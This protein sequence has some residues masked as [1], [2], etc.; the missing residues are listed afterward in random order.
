MF[1]VVAVY[2]LCVSFVVFLFEGFVLVRCLFGGRFFRV[3]CLFVL[4]FWGA[5]L[6]LCLCSLCLSL[7]FSWLF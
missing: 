5:C 3:F 6:L 1:V 4:L 2:V 7:W